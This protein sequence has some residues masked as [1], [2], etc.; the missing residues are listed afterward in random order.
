MNLAFER[1]RSHSYK[2][3]EELEKVL[4]TYV[5]EE[6]EEIHPSDI[7]LNEDGTFS[8]GKTQ[9]QGTRSSLKGL[10]R[11]LRIPN[12]FA[13]R[14]PIDLLQRNIDRLGEEADFNAKFI[15]RNDGVIV[16]FVKED[17][18]GIPHTTLFEPLMNK[19]KDTEQLAGI[20]SDNWLGLSIT[21]GEGDVFTSFE[22]MGKND[23][24]DMGVAIVNSPTGHMTTQ[25]RILLHRL[26]CM[27][28]IIGPSTF[29]GIKCRP[30]PNRNLIAVVDGFIEKIGKMFYN[31]QDLQNLIRLMDRSVSAQELKSIFNSVKKITGDIEFVDSEILGMDSEDRKHI[32]TEF[33]KFKQGHIE[34]LPQPDVSLYDIFNNITEQAKTFDQEAKFKLE[35]FAG[36]LMGNQ[37]IA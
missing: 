32:L 8:I 13:S 16:N 26:F 28:Q 4:N 27:N 12:P 6:S 30:K 17:F 37:E 36:K 22:G 31:T 14:I 7:H 3:F 25:A 20:I 21:K 18:V 24:Y 34:E 29:D 19:Y 2:G 5:Y 1:E 33:R 11:I 23:M 10:C 9:L 15:Q 35:A